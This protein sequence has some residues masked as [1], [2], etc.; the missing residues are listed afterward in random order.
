MKILTLISS[1]LLFAA[2]PAFAQNTT[3]ENM[4]M[5]FSQDT[6]VSVSRGMTRET[7]DFILGTANETVATNIWVYWDFNPKNVP[8]DLAKYNTLV[9]VFNE[10]RVTALRLCESK[11]VRELVAKLKTKTDTKTVAAK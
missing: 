3:S 11:P 7:V 10:G 2:V 1:L 6:D 9:V 5:I 4:A 8:A